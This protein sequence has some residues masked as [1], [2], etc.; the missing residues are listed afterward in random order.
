MNDGHKL[1]FELP[2]QVAL[3]TSCSTVGK[4]RAT[5][6]EQLFLMAGAAS[7]G[8]TVH[9]LRGPGVDFELETR[10]VDFYLEFWSLSLNQE[11]STAWQN[12]LC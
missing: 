11:T 10:A 2:G 7:T 12:E 5:N 4:I 6:F 3:P 8:Q 9:E 1:L